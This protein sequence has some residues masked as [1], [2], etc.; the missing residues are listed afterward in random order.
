MRCDRNHGYG[1]ERHSRGIHLGRPR[2]RLAPRVACSTADPL[3]RR[4][5]SLLRADA[6]AMSLPNMP[7]ALYTDEGG[8]ALW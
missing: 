7:D 5:V 3:P 6:Q 1:G 2:A 4:G 8:G